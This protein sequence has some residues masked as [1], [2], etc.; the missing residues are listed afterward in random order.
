MGLSCDDEAWRVARTGDGDGEDAAIAASADLRDELR[1]DKR[2][3][4]DST[5]AEV[6]GAG[7]AA[8]GVATGSGAGEATTGDATAAAGAGDGAGTITAAADDGEV[9]TGSDAAVEATFFAG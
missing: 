4:D 1:R 9:A 5:L 8:A 6:S 2:F 7:V 3:A